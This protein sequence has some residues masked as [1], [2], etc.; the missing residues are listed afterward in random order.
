MTG[1]K[2]HPKDAEKVNGLVLKVLVGIVKA[3]GLVLA[4]LI[5]LLGRVL[6]TGTA[7]NLGRG[8]GRALVG[9]L[10]LGLLVTGL[11][12]LLAVSPWLLLAVPVVAIVAVV[13]LRNNWFA[14]D[15]DTLPAA[16]AAPAGPVA[17][18]PVAGFP[19]PGALALSGLPDADDDEPVWANL[20]LDALPDADDTAVWDP[21]TA[22]LPAE[23]PVPAPVEVWDPTTSPLPDADGPR[24]PGA[25]GP[26]F[27]GA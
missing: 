23:Q 11:G 1:P 8:A 13:G 14:A 17:A 19:A 26:R 5:A 3:A 16:A 12:S 10:A 7:A 9:L 25:D 20:D 15:A 18:S 27:R 21:T 24:F 6:G 22:P 2:I 4:L